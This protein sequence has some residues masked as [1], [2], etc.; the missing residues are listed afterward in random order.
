MFVVNGRLAVEEHPQEHGYF[1]VKDLLTGKL[2]STCVRTMSELQELIELPPKKPMV[3]VRRS[4]V[5]P[6]L[7]DTDAPE[8]LEQWRHWFKEN[9]SDWNDVEDIE[10][11]LRPG[12]SYRKKK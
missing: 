8:A 6:S 1:R 3:R 2:L 5:C 12:R 11:E 9:A 10:K 4:R 7:D